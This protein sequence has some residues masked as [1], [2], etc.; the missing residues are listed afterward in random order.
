MP[1]VPPRL[2]D[3]ASGGSQSECAAI[4]LVKMFYNENGETNKRAVTLNNFLRYAR[5]LC[6][7][8]SLAYT[9]G[10]RASE[11]DV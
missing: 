1:L 10:A 3:R 5:T 4:L 8:S 7:Y 9:T 11:Y 6:T 2:M